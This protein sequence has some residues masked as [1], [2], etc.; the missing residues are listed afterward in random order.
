MESI[1]DWKQK[2]YLAEDSLPAED[3]LGW[4]VH[5]DVDSVI[6]A[7]Y[8]FGAEHPAI[9][10]VI[11]GTGSIDHLETNVA[12]LEKPSLPPEDAQRIRDLFGKIGEYA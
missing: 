5:G 3:P 8:K 9:S 12:A 6:S 4:L 10:T 7:A 11:T 2:G 1:S